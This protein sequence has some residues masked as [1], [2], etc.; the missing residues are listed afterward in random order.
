MSPESNL[1]Y[2]RKL[3]PSSLFIRRTSRADKV[4]RTDS[5]VE[6]RESKKR[7]KGKNS[8]VPDEAAHNEPPHLNLYCLLSRLRKFN[9]IRPRGYNTFSCS[10]QRSMKFFLLINVK[11]PINDGILTFM[12]GKNSILGLSEPTKSRI[13]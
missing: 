3:L 4:C 8:I 2:T 7:K 13:S 6:G 5:I 10:T 9:M 12:G 1:T 11:M